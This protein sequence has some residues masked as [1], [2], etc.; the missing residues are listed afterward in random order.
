MAS[1]TEQIARL[2]RG[3]VAAVRGEGAPPPHA[4]TLLLLLATDALLIAAH[5]VSGLVLPRVPDALNVARDLSLAEWVGYGKWLAAV[6]LLGIA[7]SR[8][9]AHVLAAIAILLAVML[10]DDA[11]QIHER[12]GALFAPA[13]APVGPLSAQDLGELAVFACF[14]AILLPLLVAGYL[15]TPAAD[16]A[17]ACR[18]FSALALFVLFGVG[19]D[20]LHPLFEPLPFGEQVAH[21]FEDGGEMAV[22]SLIVANA[23]ALYLAT[24]R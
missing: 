12:G 2:A 14:G 5:I 20:A 22:A 1:A 23:A 9:R 4:P 10:A 7:W 21:I 17:T 6:W 16:R 19:V 8:G 18:L 3:T 15:A 24:R 13:L 11:L